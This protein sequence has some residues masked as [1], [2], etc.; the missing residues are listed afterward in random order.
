MEFEIRLS[1][2][3]EVRLDGRRGPLGPTKT[4]LLLASLAWDAGRSVSV[5]SLVHRIWDEHPPA[6]ARETLH[7]HISRVRRALRTA[8]PDAPA[9]TSRTN[10]YVLHVDPDRV[11]LRAY[12]GRVEQA[13]A[14]KGS[15]G[16]AALRLL[17]RADAHRYG[18][19]L[20][21]ISGSW[22]DHL[23]ATVGETTLMAAMTRAELLV[24]AQKFTEA[25]PVLAPLVSEHPVDE[26]LVGL[27]AVA[28]HGGGR[29][30]EATRL[31]QRTRQRVIRDVGLDGGRRLH[32]IQEGI[33]AGTP[34]GALYG[35]GP[36]RRP[37]ARPGRPVPDNLPRDVPW[38]GRREESRRI[39]TALREGGGEGG[40]GAVVTIE[41]MG[42]VG[43]TALAVHCGHEVA[44][45][46]PDGRCF[47]RLGG[48]AADRTAG[49]PNRALTTLLRV[50][51]PEGKE[52]PR[53]TEELTSMWRSL[54]RDRRMLV[55]LD[56]A[57]C[58]E[59]V[60]QLLPGASPTAVV[61]TSRRRLTGLP[62][63]R[64]VPLDVLPRADAIALFEQRLGPGR[65]SREAEVADIVRFCGHLPLAVEIAASRLLARSSWTAADLL[66]QLTAGAGGLDELRDGERTLEHVFALSYRALSA[67][68]QLVFRRISLH[69]GMEFGPHAVAALTGLSLAATERALE[70]L[71][72][73]HLVSEPAPHR[74]TL[75]DLLRKYAR[76]L[77]EAEGTKS[78]AATARLATFYM[79]AADRADRLVH[80]YRSRTGV[81]TDEFITLP[82]INDVHT[83]EQWV[84]SESGNL[85]DTL[86]WISGHGSEHQLALCVHVLT[87][88]LDMRGHPATTEP[89][90]RRAVDHWAAAGN[91]GARARALLDLGVAHSHHS[92][93]EEAISAAGAAREL[94]RALGDAELEIEC[95]DQMCISL[96]QAGRYRAIQS[97]QEGILDSL[98]QTGNSLQIARSYNILGVTH[99]HLSEFDSARAHFD[100]ALGQFTAI[101]HERGIFSTLNNM[102][103]LATRTGDPEGAENAYRKAI[104]LALKRSD[105][106]ELAT[107][108]MNLANALIDLG[109]ADEALTLS[110]HSLDFFRSVGDRRRE[111]IALNRIG[112][113]HRT[114]GRGEQA[115]PLHVAALALARRIGAAGEVVDATHEAALSHMATGRTA[116][117]LT[118]AEESFNLS[119]QIGAHA[120]ADRASHTLA[121]LRDIPR[122]TAG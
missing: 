77:S 39:T 118:Y 19:P 98:L 18:E 112:R 111:A 69:T 52:L 32:R 105:R 99:L 103:E 117:A 65:P 61:V 58:S 24:N 96:W 94:A 12:T 49:T 76:S 82:E 2:S 7:T 89:L 64:P 119:M 57:V 31:L 121:A 22:P 11:D 53:D 23:R 42:G 5:D 26:A 92:R 68:Q 8:G 63:A 44:D 83:A 37:S 67:D 72:T 71:L 93:Y 35:E 62:G 91:S 17:E 66:R 47:V 48:H 46:H 56:D 78:R 51:G 74:F 75:H 79:A 84:I 85:S 120:E 60:R 73:R 34:A 115:I 45:R 90:L 14:L 109:K 36:R 21:G 20:A 43:K 87:G 16:E 30:A 88:L 29:T 3:V 110:H 50:L 86:E 70:Q 41:G 100:S 106:R 116:Q 10:S 108:R 122:T 54:A 114:A 38:T 28:L 27:L 101:D 95:V 104:S 107:L 102:A 15:D 81:D 4:R 97:L 40:P 59:Q 13:R 33:L 25:V 55:I 6:T 9:I 80:P 113:A 1:G